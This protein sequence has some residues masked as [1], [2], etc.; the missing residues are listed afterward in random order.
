VLIA[1]LVPGY[2]AAVAAQRHAEPGW[3]GAQ[4]A[5]IWIVVLAAL[6]APD[7]DVVYNSLFRGFVNH[8]TLWQICDPERKPS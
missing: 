2:F 4:R 3:D 7:A 6:V 1:H 8:S 5:A